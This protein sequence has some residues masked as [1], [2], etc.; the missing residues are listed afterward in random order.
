MYLEIWHCN[1]TGVY[2]GV[3]AEGNG[4]L[5]DLD[6]V[7]KT[8]LRGI[9]PTNDDGVAQFETIFPGHYTNRTN[10]IHIMA[11]SN[12]TTVQANGTLGLQNY[13]SHVGQT[14]F[15]QRLIDAVE[16]L[17]PYNINTQPK[18]PNADDSV[19]AVLDGAGDGV[20]PLMEYTL[21]G[22]SIED[23]LFAWLAFG[24]DSSKSEAIIP[25]GWLEEEGGVQNPSFVQEVPDVLLSYFATHT[26]TGA[27]GVTGSV[28]PA[29]S[30]AS[31]SHAHGHGPGG[32][33]PT[34]TRHPPGSGCRGS[35]CSCE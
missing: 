3:H 9:Q 5:S 29:T 27:S 6:N 21:L 33:H 32:S 13:A 19:L 14:Y 22:D 17:A 18:T 30:T 11:H 35:K 34:N 1:A 2:A 12:I 31:T 10:H 4:D 26:V 24:I 23:G 16:S 25:A 28:P 8:F 20:D 15:D 7:N